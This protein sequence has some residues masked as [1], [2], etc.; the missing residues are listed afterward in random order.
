MKDYSKT[1]QR[2]IICFVN[3]RNRICKVFVT[4][5]LFNHAFFHTGKFPNKIKFPLILIKKIKYY[6][7]KI[8][9]RIYRKSLQFTFFLNYLQQNLHKPWPAL[10][11]RLCL[12]EKK[13]NFKTKNNIIKKLR[14]NKSLN[15]KTVLEHFRRTYR[16]F[17]LQ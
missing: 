12:F 13:L 15:Q 4:A 1:T 10:D 9:N 14:I 5:F 17:L 7:I 2:T 11:F 3:L 6:S 8:S 16:H